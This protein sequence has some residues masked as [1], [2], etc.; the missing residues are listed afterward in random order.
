MKADERIIVAHWEDPFS[1]SECRTMQAPGHV[2]YALHG[3]H[4]LYGRDVLLYIGRSDA[5]IG[6]RLQDHEK[7]VADEYDLMT[8]RLA[9]IGQFTTWEEW[10]TANGIRKQ[11]LA[12]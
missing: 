3:A 6:Y 12:S 9:S 10:A 4:H 5:G 11:T 8:V 7:W 2:L 1:W